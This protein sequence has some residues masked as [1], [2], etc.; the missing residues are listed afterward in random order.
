M[1]NNL[2]NTHYYSFYLVVLIKFIIFVYINNIDRNMNKLCSYCKE[3][4]ELEDFHLNIR[5][6]D[7]YSNACKNC[8]KEYDKTYRKSDKIQDFYKSES[9]RD[10]KR[11]YR[12]LRFEIDLENQLLLQARARAKKNNLPFNITIE[13]IVIPEFCPILEIKLERKEYGKGGS[14]QRNSPSLDKIDPKLGYVKGNVIVI[15]MKANVMKNNATKE[16]LLNF[17]KN[18]IKII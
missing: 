5:N 16:E 18:I 1:W 13:D 11:E 9:Y 14:F 2:N 4:K 6:K 12:K 7:G 17:S 15:S 3:T 10:R 8:K